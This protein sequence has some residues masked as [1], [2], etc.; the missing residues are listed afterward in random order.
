M[1]PRSRYTLAYGLLALAAVLSMFLR[2]EMKAVEGV[3]SGVGISVL[4]I[5]AYATFHKTLEKEYPGVKSPAANEPVDGII[6]LLIFALFPGVLPAMALIGLKFTAV[7]ILAIFGAFLW[8]DR[9]LVVK[10]ARANPPALARAIP[11]PSGHF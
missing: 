9:Q 2:V 5:G 11:G 7:Y 4:I 8:R 10:R 6:A 3:L 1:S